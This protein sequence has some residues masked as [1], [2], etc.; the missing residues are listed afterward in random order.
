M[1]MLFTQHIPP[2]SSEA[3]L[4]IRLDVQRSVSTIPGEEQAPS[5]F[6]VRLLIFRSEDIRQPVKQNSRTEKDQDVRNG[7]I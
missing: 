1:F 3:E 7:G 5:P 2:A 4:F 6:P